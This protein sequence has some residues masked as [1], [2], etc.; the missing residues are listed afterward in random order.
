MVKTGQQG[1]ALLYSEET[2]LSLFKIRI[3]F[4]F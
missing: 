2:K 3:T 4:V 1:K